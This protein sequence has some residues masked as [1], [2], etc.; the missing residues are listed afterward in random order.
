[1]RLEKELIRIDSFRTMSGPGH[2]EGTALVRLKGWQ[3]VGYEGSINGER[4]QTVYLPELQ[5]LSTP[6]LTFEGTPEKLADPRRGAPAGTAH[7][8]PADP[9]GRPAQQGCDPGGGAEARSK[10]LFRWLWMSR[11]A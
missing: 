3:V 8:R 10:R 1:M 11:S 6:R 7:L 9:G 4:F 5:I 2:I